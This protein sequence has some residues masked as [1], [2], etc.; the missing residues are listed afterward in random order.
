MSGL[1]AMSVAVM[2]RTQVTD[3]IPYHVVR[4]VVEIA[5]CCTSPAT[6]SNATEG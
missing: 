4:I 1:L 2:P 6:A 3:G 5:G